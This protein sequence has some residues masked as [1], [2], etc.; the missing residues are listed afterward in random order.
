[1]R[2]TMSESPRP[3]RGIPPLRNSALRRAFTQVEQ[4]VEPRAFAIIVVGASSGGVEAM[5]K[6]FAPLPSTIPAAMFTVLHTVLC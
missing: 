3:C 2:P 1:M 4:K 5:Q 6:L